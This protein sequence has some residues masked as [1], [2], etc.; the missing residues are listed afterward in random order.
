MLNMKSQNTTSTI[1]SSKQPADAPRSPYLVMF[2]AIL[3]PGMG[4]VMNRTPGRGLLMLF[5][6]LCLGV[7]SYQ[8]T[9]P[10]HSMLGRFAGGLFIYSISVMDAYKWARVRLTV[11]QTA[12]AAS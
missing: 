3:L 12:C 11:H 7:V 9:T 10:E 2:V 5:F 4:Q 8:L 6:M 1:R